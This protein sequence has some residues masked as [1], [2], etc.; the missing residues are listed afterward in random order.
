MGPLVPFVWQSLQFTTLMALLYDMD[1]KVTM[2][3]KEEDLANQDPELLNSTREA[4]RQAAIKQHAF[5][6]AGNI[7]YGDDGLPTGNVSF[8]ESNID[9]TKYKKQNLTSPKDGVPAIPETNGYYIYDPM[10]EWFTGES[11]IEKK[12]TSIFEGIRYITPP[13]IRKKVGETAAF[14]TGGLYKV[15]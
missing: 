12:G 1:G 9:L 11:G 8:G 3:I 5:D 7:E 6:M 14:V 4:V 2:D 13:E 15:K 10:D